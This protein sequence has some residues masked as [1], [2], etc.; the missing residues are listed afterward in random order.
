MKPVF[1]NIL[2]VVSLLF[3]S[4]NCSFQ[5]SIFNELNKSKRGQNLII[6]PLSIF[7]ILSL[8]ANGAKGQTQKEM[9]QTLQGA[10]LDKLNYINYEIL[11]IF[12]KFE[13]VEIAN[14][15]MSRFTPLKE[16][17]EIAEKYC[18]PLEQLIS[19]QQVNNWCSEKTHGKITK[20][21]DQLNASV[22]MILLNA[23][24]FKGEWSKQFKES[25]TKKK[26]FYN[27]GTEIKEVDTMNKLDHF[28]YYEDTKVQAIQLPF[29]KDDMSALI[30]LPRENTDI[31]KYISSLNSKETSLSDLISKLKY[32]KV[33]LELPK[34]QLE[35][36][37]SLKE[38]LK[39][40][41]M[42]TAFSNNADLTGLRE[43]RNLKIDDV[44]HKTFL[45]VNENGTEAAAVTA[46]IIKY[47]SARPV[48]E[49]VFQM[50]VNRPFLFMLRSNKL[51][52]DYDMLFMS[53]IE[54]ID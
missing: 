14:A 16:F 13:T 52:S 46:V 53:K 50:K 18:A 3:N 4:L 10:D 21:L 32:S 2:L 28:S 7:Q 54:S 11:D 15:V 12:Q 44:L 30:I 23:V 49:K 39:D 35:F 47:T 40:M 36:F 1:I 31:N 45:K 19:V 41:G 17:N 6:S 22:Q 38:T 8:T 51:P 20:I 43:E 24:Y 9:V 29:T 25:L 42:T 33:N 37:S 48:E 27:L 26:V 34:F 5:V